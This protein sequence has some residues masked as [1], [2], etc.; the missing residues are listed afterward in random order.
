MITGVDSAGNRFRIMMMPVD[1]DES[2]FW[3]MYMNGCCGIRHDSEIEAM[4]SVNSIV[5]ASGRT[6]EWESK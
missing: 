3:F 6:I 2:M 5:A 1:D 4:E